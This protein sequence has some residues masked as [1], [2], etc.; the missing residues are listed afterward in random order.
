M[1]YDDGF[2]SCKQ[3]RP[4]HS[5]GEFWF[6]KNSEPNE[7][8]TNTIDNVSVGFVKHRLYYIPCDSS[9]GVDSLEH[10]SFSL[11]IYKIK[12]KMSFIKIP[13]L[14]NQSV[15]SFMNDKCVC[16]SV[17]TN[18]PFDWSG[19][20]LFCCASR[21]NWY[22]NGLFFLEIYWLWNVGQA[23]FCFFFIWR[24][25]QNRSYIPRIYLNVCKMDAS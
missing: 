14:H 2:S 12:Q 16:E 15:S 18:C 4:E 8:R 1:D 19:R 22:C 17:C 6:D 23:K 11:I 9:S 5:R 13:S 25:Y 20:M 3:S 24:S 7:N 21:R 10:L